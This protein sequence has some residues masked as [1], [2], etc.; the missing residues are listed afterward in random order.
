MGSI[1]LPVLQHLNEGQSAVE[2]RKREK[3]ICHDFATNRLALIGFIQRI[4]DF[5]SRDVN[6][7]AAK[8]D[9]A[10]YVLVGPRIDTVGVWGSNPLA[11]TNPFNNL[12]AKNLQKSLE[13]YRSTVGVWRSTIQIALNLNRPR[14]SSGVL[15]ERPALYQLWK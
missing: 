2:R 11:P 10:L 6:F 7:Y 3:L 12:R 8:N 4:R 14:G 15:P 1:T 9:Y 13:H 5:S